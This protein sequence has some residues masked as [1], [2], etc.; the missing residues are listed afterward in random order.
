MNSCFKFWLNTSTVYLSWKHSPF[1]HIF[2]PAKKVGFAFIYG[3]ASREQ[4]ITFT[5]ITK[6]ALK[7]L[8]KKK[9]ILCCIRNSWWTA[10]STVPQ[11]YAISLFFFLIWISIYFPYTCQSPFLPINC[12]YSQQ[13]QHLCIQL[14]GWP[15]QSFQFPGKSLYKYYQFPAEHSYQAS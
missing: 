12:N 3:R 8:R 5:N 10:T 9:N 6:V 13:S 11:L 7:N 4:A 14:T 1:K 15:E 2:V